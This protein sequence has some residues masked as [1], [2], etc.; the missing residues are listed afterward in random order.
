M[1][2][3]VWSC[4]ALLRRKSSSGYCREHLRCSLARSRPCSVCV[5]QGLGGWG[6]DMEEPCAGPTGL[7]KLLSSTSSRSV[8]ILR[9]TLGVNCQIMSSTSAGCLRSPP[10]PPHRL[11]RPSFFICS[12][13]GVLL[14]LVCD[15]HIPCVV[16]LYLP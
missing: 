9:Q 5:R 13:R 1:A 11:G 10:P 16:V 6:T 8:K 7:G 3:G 2:A 15:G 4:A 12:P 14:P